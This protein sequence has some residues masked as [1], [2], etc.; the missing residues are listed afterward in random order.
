MKNQKDKGILWK[1]YNDTLDDL[2][3]YSYS[4]TLYSPHPIMKY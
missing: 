3:F 4:K 1:N 2:K